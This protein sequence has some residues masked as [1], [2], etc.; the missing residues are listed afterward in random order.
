MAYQYVMPLFLYRKKT[1]DSNTEM[2]IASPQIFTRF[3]IM[4]SNCG[5][6]SEMF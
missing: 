1:L 6:I 3:E 2:N 4:I 5:L